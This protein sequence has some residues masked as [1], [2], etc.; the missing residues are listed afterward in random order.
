V[1]NIK[2]KTTKQKQQQLQPHLSS[3]H[4]RTKNI[5]VRTA[6]LVS[7]EGY[8]MLCQNVDAMG[9][10]I[11]NMPYWKDACSKE[12]SNLKSKNLRTCRTNIEELILNSEGIQRT[13]KATCVY[14]LHLLDIDLYLN[15]YAWCILLVETFSTIYDTNCHAWCSTDHVYIFIF[16]FGIYHIKFASIFLYHVL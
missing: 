7:W 10:A 4:C 9:T 8:K 1:K 16:T 5:L 15:N 13:P 11:P 2:K 14:C 6:I 12:V 3:D